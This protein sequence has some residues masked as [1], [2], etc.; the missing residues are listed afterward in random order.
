MA[1]SSCENRVFTNVPEGFVK[2][3][4]SITKL[5]IGPAARPEFTLYQHKLSDDVSMH[6]AVV[7]FKGGRSAARHFRFVGRAMPTERHAMQMA[8]REAIARLRDI[9][10]TMK[11]RRYRYL[12]CHVPYTSHYAFACHR[13]ERDEAIEMVV[14]YLKALEES[15]DNLMD[16]LV[17]ARMDLVRGGPASRKE[18]LNTAPPLTFVSSSA[19]Y[20]PAVLA[21]ARRL[22]TT[23]EF[24]RVIAPTP[25][26]AAPPGAPALPPVAPA[27]SPQRSVTRQEPAREEVE[28]DSPGPLSLAIDKGKEIF[29]I[30]D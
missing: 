16:D 2:L 23:E 26:R 13:G 1:G 27:P 3:L 17:A 4:V 30:S 25:V 7:Q 21:T 15:F 9:L 14:E 18:L 24:D 19:S 20:A 11:T 5:A 6:Q 8:A 28:V 10:P 22:P 12:P 29:T